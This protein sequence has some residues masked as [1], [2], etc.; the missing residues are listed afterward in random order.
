MTRL[1]DIAPRLALAR[2]QYL[3]VQRRQAA[4][5]LRRERAEE[6][7]DGRKKCRATGKL[8]YQTMESAKRRL[9]HLLLRVPGHYPCRA[10]P[11]E[12]CGGWHLT[13]RPRRSVA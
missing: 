5:A 7:A 1:A 2:E 11:C 8:R 12:H 6:R 4:A 3:E 9:A 10:Y 13:S